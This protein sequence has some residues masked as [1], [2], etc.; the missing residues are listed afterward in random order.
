MPLSVFVCS[1]KQGVGIQR[2]NVYQAKGVR[3][4]ASGGGRFQA[5]VPGGE[6]WSS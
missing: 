2:V 1:V 3:V 6:K 5:G 4:P